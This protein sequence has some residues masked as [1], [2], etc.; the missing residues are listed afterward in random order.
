MLTED[1]FSQFYS[2]SPLI[3][4][5]SFLP[6]PR[7][8]YEF[9]ITG[10][11][12][13]RKLVNEPLPLSDPYAD[14]HEKLTRAILALRT[15]KKGRVGYE[16]IH[17]RPRYFCPYLFQD[18]IGGLEYVPMGQYGLSAAEVQPFQDHARLVFADLHP[19]LEIAC[20]RLGD[21]ET[22]LKPRD[23]IM[24]AVIGLE[25]MLL[26]Q[27]GKEQYRGEMRYR[28]SLNYS[29]LSEGPED[30][31][32]NFYTARSL[33]DLRS[34]IAHGGQTKE[35]VSIGSDTLTLYQAA[36]FACETLRAAIKRFLPGGKAPEYLAQHFWEDAY[37]APAASPPAEESGR[38][39]VT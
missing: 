24:D 20:S 22:R 32:R 6:K 11:Y 33:Y 8:L 36:D 29:S 18:R 23:A 34:T 16:T 5:L 26:A 39:Q 13:L 38:G 27:A 19:S 15:F 17:L 7:W 12:R 28:F 9:A 37:F 14:L 4:A 35:Q 10:E 31:R 25:A 3:E 30:R 2:V 1:E 21:A